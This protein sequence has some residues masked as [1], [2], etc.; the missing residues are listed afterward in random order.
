[1]EVGICQRQLVARNSS[2][3]Y[4]G[5]KARSGYY[6]VVWFTNDCINAN[7]EDMAVSTPVMQQELSWTSSNNMAYDPNDDPN[8]Q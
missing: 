1:M 5:M 4:V 6:V 7:S 8:A 3:E 2:Q